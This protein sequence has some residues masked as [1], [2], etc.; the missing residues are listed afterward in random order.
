[1][2]RKKPNKPD[3]LKATTLNDSIVVSDS[4]LKD[5][6]K[7]EGNVVFLPSGK[8][9]KIQQE[10]KPIQYTD[11]RTLYPSQKPFQ[12]PGD[13]KIKKKRGRPKKQKN[14]KKKNKK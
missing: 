12:Q 9:V 11:F 7:A 10:P 5:Y 13:F 4:F 1:M 14:L 8:E 2:T 6:L 3:E